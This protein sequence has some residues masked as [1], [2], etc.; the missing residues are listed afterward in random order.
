MAVSVCAQIYE[1][2]Q[3]DDFSTEQVYL[4]SS[5][6]KTAYRLQGGVSGCLIDKSF[7]RPKRGEGALKEAVA[8]LFIRIITEPKNGVYKFPVTL[9]C[10]TNRLIIT[11]SSK[12]SAYIKKHWAD[13][14]VQ[15]QLIEDQRHE[16]VVNEVR[17]YT[18]LVGRGGQGSTKACMIQ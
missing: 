1:S 3:S 2:L 9:I 8:G 4:L 12:V 5:S 10:E 14:E 15:I 13:G 7:D 17:R 18:S 16:A 6:K 11:E